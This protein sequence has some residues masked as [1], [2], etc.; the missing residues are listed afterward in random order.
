M[1]ILISSI[2]SIITFFVDSVL[3]ESLQKSFGIADGIA[4]ILSFFSILLFIISQV[5]LIVSYIRRKGFKHLLKWSFYLK[6]FKKEDKLWFKGAYY[7]FV[8]G[9]LLIPIGIFSFTLFGNF[10]N[11]IKSIFV[12]VT[13]SCPELEK[14]P[15]PCSFKDSFLS[16]LA[17]VPFLMVW[18]G[19]YFSLITAIIVSFLGGIAGFIVSKVLARKPKK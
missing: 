12:N 3:N 6:E 2:I 19:Y 5:Y 9:L 4:Y 1:G 13:W 17:I 11:A 15:R 14:M 16:S 10:A 8:I 7:G 18:F